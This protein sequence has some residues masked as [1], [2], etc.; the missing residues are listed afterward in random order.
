M[1]YAATEEGGGGRRIGAGSPCSGTTAGQRHQ[2][3]LERAAGTTPALE[4]AFGAQRTG[5]SCA[6][7]PAWWKA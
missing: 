6:S 1:V 3:P 2:S 4:A 7:S 5:A